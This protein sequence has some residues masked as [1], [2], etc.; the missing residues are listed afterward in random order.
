MK[1]RERWEREEGKIKREE[2]EMC[3]RQEWAKWE[4]EEGRGEGKK[5]RREEEGRRERNVSGTE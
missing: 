5:G 4:K 3:E 2:R 1:E